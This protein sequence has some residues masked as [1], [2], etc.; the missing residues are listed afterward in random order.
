[1][2]P[3]T[4]F[5]RFRK[6]KATFHF[7]TEQPAPVDANAPAISVPSA[8][9]G[10]V[11][12]SC[13]STITVTCLKELYN[14]VGYTP[15]ANIGNEIAATGYLEEFAN[16]ADLQA[17]YEDQVPA[18]AAVNASFKVISINGLCL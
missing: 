17:F 13:N 6:N 5:S 9:G 10:K 18:A 12:A 8:S 2:Q 16:F 15:R 3:T 11:D 4:L 14:A 1:M 7:D